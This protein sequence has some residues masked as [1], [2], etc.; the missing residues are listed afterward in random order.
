MGGWR[1]AA[2]WV[3]LKRRSP[4]T[5]SPLI[6]ANGGASLKFPGLDC[7]FLFRSLMLARL[8]HSVCEASIP[9]VCRELGRMGG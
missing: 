1:E 8:K 5:M 2:G 7:D 6:F 9:L 4:H 3:G